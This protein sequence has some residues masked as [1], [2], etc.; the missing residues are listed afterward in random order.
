MITY[1]IPTTAQTNRLLILSLTAIQEH[2]ALLWYP[3][4]KG[5]T[6]KFIA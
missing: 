6:A 3:G 4:F 1:C 5:H 2:R